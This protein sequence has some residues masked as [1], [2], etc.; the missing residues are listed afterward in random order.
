MPSCLSISVIVPV[1]NGVRYLGEAI[2]SIGRQDLAPLEIIVVDDGST[3]GTA[4]LVESLGAAVRG[5]W[6]PNS[7]PAAARNCGIALARGELVA[8][9]D[10][11]DWWPPSSLRRQHDCLCQHAELGGVL[12]ATQLMVR[13]DA[14]DAAWVPWGAPQPTLNLGGALIRRSVFDQVGVFGR[15]FAFAEDADWILRA[16]EAGIRFGIQRGVALMARRHDDNMT[17]Q[18]QPSEA[19]LA[20]ALRRSLARRSRPAEQRTRAAGLTAFVECEP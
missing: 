17:N 5:V 10:A 11:D 18:L 2:A 20:L 16:R 1:Y 15:E 8:F 3:D 9:L 12:G 14:S 6:Q 7:G 13:G 19:Y 4:A